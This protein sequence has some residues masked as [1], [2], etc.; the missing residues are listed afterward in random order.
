MSNL[1]LD[2]GRSFVCPS[3]FLYCWTRILARRALSL[4]F[5]LGFTVAA[6]AGASPGIVGMGWTDANRHAALYDVDAA[7]GAASN[8]RALSI[9]PV[10]NIEADAGGQ[11][12]S[13]VGG[14]TVSPNSLYRINASTGQSSLVAHL[15][16]W[17]TMGDIAYNAGT[18]EIFVVETPERG[19]SG[20]SLVAIDPQIGTTRRVGDL[21]SDVYFS[22]MSFDGDGRLFSIGADGLLYELSS[23]TAEIVATTPISPPVLAAT[24]MAF[25]PSMGLLVSAVRLSGGVDMIYQLNPSTGNLTAIGPSGTSYGLSSLAILPEPATLAIFAVGAALFIRRSRRPVR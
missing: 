4:A 11:L 17:H 8:P 9:S 14:Y 20:Q 19:S 25:H 1:L 7:T 18:G 10:Q 2:K 16:L 23:Q 21:P 22:G 15:D 24:G 6:G 3:A 12:Y 5:A 13:V